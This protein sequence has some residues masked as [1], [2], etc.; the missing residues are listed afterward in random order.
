MLI[1]LLY[2]MFAALPQQ[3]LDLSILW[4]QPDLQVEEKSCFPGMDQLRGCRDQVSYSYVKNN[5]K[6]YITMGICDRG[7]VERMI[8]TWA[9]QGMNGMIHTQ[10]R[11]MT[12]SDVKGLSEVARFVLFP[13]IR[14]YACT[15]M[16]DLK[17]SDNKTIYSLDIEDDVQ[18][19]FFVHVYMFPILGTADVLFS[20]SLDEFCF[21]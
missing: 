20:V 15:E 16:I 13:E 1:S 18:S 5:R 4:R 9:H 2:G 12:D 11:T 10:S 7:N 3:D 6:K 14:R 17:D 8:R 21:L 19:P